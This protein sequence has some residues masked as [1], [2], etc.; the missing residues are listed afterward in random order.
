MNS[1]R[2]EKQTLSVEVPKNNKNVG[3]I[4][5]N[6]HQAPE[7]QHHSLKKE[8]PFAFKQ[9]YEPIKTNESL[10]ANKRINEKL[11]EIPSM[12]KKEVI[13]TEE[14]EMESQDGNDIFQSESYGMDFTVDSEAINQFDHNESLED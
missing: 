6:K 4:V 5:S 11:A 2:E 14:K 10:P 13:N 12:K 8:E 1:V 3:Q 7:S 9:S